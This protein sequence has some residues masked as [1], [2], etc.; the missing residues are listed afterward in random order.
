ATSFPGDEDDLSISKDGDTFYYTTTSSTAKGRDLYSIKWDGKDLK[1]ITKGGTNPAGVSM[2]RDGKYLYYFKTGGALA[3]IELKSGSAEQLPYTARLKINYLAER[4]Q[5]FEE[6]WR[7]IR[8]GYYD[9]KFNGHD[10]VKLHDKYKERCVYASTSNDFRDMF[11]LLLGE[12]NSS[13]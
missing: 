10:W 6:A 11:S 5:V 9:P 7:T 2:D 8:D 1:E 13:H 12:I 3:R 4:E